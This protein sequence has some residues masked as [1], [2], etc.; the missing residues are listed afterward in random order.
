MK[1][2]PACLF[3]KLRMT[4]LLI[5]RLLRNLSNSSKNGFF[6]V[7]QIKNFWLLFWVGFNFPNAPDQLQGDSSLLTTKSSGVSDTHLL[8]HGRMRYQKIPWIFSWIY[9]FWTFRIA[10]YLR[11]TSWCLKVSNLIFHGS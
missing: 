8:Y 7:G 11:L 1:L 3:R 10:Y 2:F 4:C 5:F 9:E 6:Y